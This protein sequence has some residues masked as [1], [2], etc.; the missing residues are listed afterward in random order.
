[1]L[2]SIPHA[3]TGLPPGLQD[4]FSEE[5]K[6]L[7]D[8]DWFVDRLYAFA[9]ELG[10][11]LLTAKAARLVVD[12]N[13]PSD[14]QPLYSASQTR[15][16]TGVLPMQC[17][18]GAAV[19]RDGEEPDAADTAGRLKLYWQPYH[20]LLWDSLQ[21]TL[22]Q[23]GHAIVLDAH[24]IRAEVPLLF[25]GVLPDLNLGSNAGTSAHASLLNSA[26]NCLQGSDY[27]L[28]VDGRFKGGYITRHYGQPDLQTH[29]LQLEIAQRIYMQESPPQW[30]E[31]RAQK[32]QSHLQN[33]LQNLIEWTPQNA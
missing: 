7:P 2:V 6:S 18:S 5:A 16:M 9:R 1:M 27:T 4:R 20:D 15:L 22:Q 8:T 26:I 13:R 21:R 11:S 19:Y 33:L 12:L 30:D 32:L 23:H 29:A 17:F 28:V 3:G 14:D 31:P 24:S 10:A 25:D